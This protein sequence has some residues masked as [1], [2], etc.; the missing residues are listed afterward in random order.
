MSESI[1][2]RHAAERRR[3][4]ALL[5]LGAGILLCGPLTHWAL[6]LF[7]ALFTR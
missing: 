1:L 5:T 2:R 4:E 6:I 7:L 3:L